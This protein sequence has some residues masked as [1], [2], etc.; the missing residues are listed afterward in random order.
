ML[1]C[2]PFAHGHR[3]HQITRIPRLLTREVGFLI[4]KLL[5]PRFEINVRIVDGDIGIEFARCEP[6]ASE[7]AR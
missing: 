3:R 2:L 1:Y 7:I 4:S 5:E 6:G